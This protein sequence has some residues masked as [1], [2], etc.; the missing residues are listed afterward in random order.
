MLD[1]LFCTVRSQEQTSY[2]FERGLKK[3]ARFNQMIENRP[4][5]NQVYFK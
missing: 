2:L 4:P 5:L 3:V 1:L